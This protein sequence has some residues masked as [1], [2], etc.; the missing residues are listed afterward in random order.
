[1]VF[2]TVPNASISPA[3]ETGKRVSPDRNQRRRVHTYRI[4]IEN[5]LPSLQ[6]DECRQG[7]RDTACH[8]EPGQTRECLGGTDA[9]RREPLSTQEDLA[10]D[11]SGRV[12]TLCSAC[13]TPY[14]MLSLKHPCCKPQITS[15]PQLAPTDDPV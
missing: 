2:S 3:S 15:Q 10:P 14:S 1:M 13:C 5:F 7:Q 6:K 11:A 8:D 4:L 12:P 9:A